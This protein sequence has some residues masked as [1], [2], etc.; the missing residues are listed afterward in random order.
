MMARVG[1]RNDLTPTPPGRQ[2]FAIHAADTGRVIFIELL[3]VTSAAPHRPPRRAHYCFYQAYCCQE[4]AQ[5]CRQKPCRRRNDSA[6]GSITRARCHARARRKHATRE[7]RHSKQERRTH[8]A[9]AMPPFRARLAGPSG[10]EK[11]DC[12][13]ACSYKPAAAA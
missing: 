5:S 6:P 4:H 2:H 3:F 8:A 13:H 7:R 11:H 9:S 10:R 1:R 12:Q